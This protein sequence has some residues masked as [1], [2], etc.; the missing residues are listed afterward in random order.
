MKARPQKKQLF[1]KVFA[2]RQVVSLI[3]ALDKIFG[4]LPHLPQKL[5]KIVSAIVP[6]TTLILGLISVVAA[7]SGFFFLV[8]SVIAWD[9]LFVLENLG[10]FLLAL[11][12][13]LLTM[14]AVK[15]LRQRDATGWIY[16]FWMQ[17]MN[18]G[19]S[20]YDII[21]GNIDQWWVT[22]IGLV[23]FT[24]LLFEIGPN[25]TYREKSQPNNELVAN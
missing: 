6:W 22:I 14:K 18:I 19:Y 24:Y 3:Q 25:Y 12:A 9:T 15:P 11:L 23:V 20:I 2:S 21:A 13:A 8:L 4:K 10:A 17:V 16:L 1:K 5:I 7:I